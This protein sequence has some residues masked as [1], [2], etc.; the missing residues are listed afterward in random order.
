MRRA[1]QTAGQ[2]SQSVSCGNF[3]FMKLSVLLLGR[4]SVPARDSDRT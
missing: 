3:G 4:S 1:E 2:T